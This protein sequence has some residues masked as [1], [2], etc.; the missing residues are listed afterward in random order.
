MMMQDHPR[1]LVQEGVNF[2]QKH[3]YN[4]AKIMVL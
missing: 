3:N 1:G 2:H 4:M